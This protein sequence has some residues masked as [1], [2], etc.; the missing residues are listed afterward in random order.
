MNQEQRKR[1]REANSAV[2]VLVALQD[3]FMESIENYKDR[4]NDQTCHELLVHY[5]AMKLAFEY[6]DLE[7]TQAIV[8][9]TNG[10]IKRSEK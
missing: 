10:Q 2:D 9:Y 3:S 6:A 8:E 1:C 4:V 5:Q 7:V